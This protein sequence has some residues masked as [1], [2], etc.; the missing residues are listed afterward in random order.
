MS[1]PYQ[2]TFLAATAADVTPEWIELR[3]GIIERDGHAI[4]AGN[5][6]WIELQEAN[7][8]NVWWPI[9]TPTGGQLYATAA[10]REAVLQRLWG[11]AK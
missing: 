5:G 11:V 7:R 10:D 6:L 3:R 9:C 4:R 2:P 8:P 1:Q